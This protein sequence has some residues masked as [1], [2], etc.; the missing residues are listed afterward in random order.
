M[1]QRIREENFQSVIAYWCCTF[2][3]TICYCIMCINENKSSTNYGIKIHPK[4]MY[5]NRPP[6]P[7]ETLTLISLNKPNVSL[8]SILSFVLS[9][10][11]HSISVIL[12]NV[13]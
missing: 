2:V 8:K 6:T 7:N 4:Y 11:F 5:I 1:S 3:S 9:V 10:Q 13:L 12:L